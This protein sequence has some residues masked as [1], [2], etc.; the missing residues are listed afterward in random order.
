MIDEKLIADAVQTVVARQIV[1]NLSPELMRE[2]LTKSVVALLSD[3]T[4][5]RQV[6]QA[7]AEQ[8]GKICAVLLGEPNW[9]ARI[10]AVVE[11]SL[12]EFLKR[13]PKALIAS[14]SEAIGG[15]SDG[16]YEKTGIILKYLNAKE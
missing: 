11:A 15:K 8:A 4:F 2:V 1:E 9:Q 6:E 16:H 10:K 14:F 3:Y 13:L 12:E 7:G 5:K